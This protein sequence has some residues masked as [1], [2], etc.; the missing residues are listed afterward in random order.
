MD[1][2]L[3]GIASDPAA[4][5]SPAAPTAPVEPLPGPASGGTGTGGPAA[6]AAPTLPAPP[7][8]PPVGTTEDGEDGIE[9]DIDFGGGA[10]GGGYSVHLSG[11][12]A[13]DAEQL[14]DHLSQRAG[15]EQPDEAD[16]G[17]GA[18]DGEGPDAASGVGAAD[19][20]GPDAT[21]G[22]DA[23][24]AALEEDQADDR[25]GS[26]TESLDETEGSSIKDLDGVREHDAGDDG[27]AGFAAQRPGE[28]DPD[29]IT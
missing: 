23:K 13:E 28:E 17:I 22:P 27:P 1:T 12:D 7:P 18:A 21:T 15:S 19:G 14:L 20:Q 16:F 5:A 2:S 9:I 10:A 3:W 29:L 8:P 25:F 24:T 6:P 26:R 4:T 11:L